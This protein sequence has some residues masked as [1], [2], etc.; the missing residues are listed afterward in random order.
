MPAFIPDIVRAYTMKLSNREKAIFKSDLKKEEDKSRM[1]S[2][3][4]YKWLPVA[5]E[6]MARTTFDYRVRSGYGTIEECA[7]KPVDTRKAVNSR[8]NGRPIADLC[9]DYD[10]PRVSFY[11]WRKRH[12]NRADIEQM[13]NETQ[14]AMYA[15]IRKQEYEK[16]R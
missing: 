14:V 10:V 5:L 4:Y 7:T 8:K 13:Q 12:P 9:H 3:E 1:H 6:H 15:E 16:V 2:E 11:K